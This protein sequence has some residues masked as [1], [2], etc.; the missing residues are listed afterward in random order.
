M[1][2][3]AIRFF[4]EGGPWMYPIVVVFGFG[5]VVLIERYLFITAAQARNKLAWNQIAPALAEHDLET[6]RERAENSDSAIGRMLQYG[7]SRASSNPAAINR[8]EVESAVEEGLM[9]QLPRYER[10]T[11]YL[12]TCANVATLLGLL[13]TIMGLIAA[14]TAVANV[15]PAEKADLLSASISIAM[16]TTAFGL[17]CAIPLL[18]AH[19]WLQAKTSRLV[20]ALEM[21]SVKFLNT[22][23]SVAGQ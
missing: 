3:T 22:V 11:P 23:S 18:I 21:A 19:T 16:N 17:M 15:N 5:L 4:Q 8:G 20:D 10:R 1:L 9:E 12:A 2:E 13:G 7:F 6:A 14:F